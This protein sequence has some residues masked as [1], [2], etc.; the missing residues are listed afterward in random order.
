MTPGLLQ[1]NYLANMTLVA[2][3]NPLVERFYYLRTKQSG[4]AIHKSNEKMDMLK[5]SPDHL[6]KHS[7]QSDAVKIS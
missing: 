7:Y 6:G 1:T 5:F 2:E 4:F 3:N